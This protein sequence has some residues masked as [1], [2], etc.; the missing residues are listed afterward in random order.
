[1]KVPLEVEESE[2]DNTH[3]DIKNFREFL[4]EHGGHT[5]GWDELDHATFVKHR[6]KHKSCSNLAE[7]LH[8]FIPVHTIEQIQRHEHWYIQYTELCNRNRAAIK[9]WRER[10]FELRAEQKYSAAE[11]YLKVSQLI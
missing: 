6:L 9:A 5:G 11:I 10:Q 8:P 1:M 2:N 3:P 4:V 7:A